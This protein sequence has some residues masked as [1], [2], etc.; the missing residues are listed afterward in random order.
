MNE[1]PVVAFLVPAFGALSA[2][3]KE[4]APIINRFAKM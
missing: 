4:P 3:H 1:L 2:N